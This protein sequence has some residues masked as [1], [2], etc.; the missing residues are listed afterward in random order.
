MK[1]SGLKFKMSIG[2]PALSCSTLI[3]GIASIVSLIFPT[4]PTNYPNRYRVKLRRGIECRC[5]AVTTHQEKRA[6]RCDRTMRHL[7]RYCA[8]VS[9]FQSISIVVIRHAKKIDAVRYIAGYLINFK[10]PSRHAHYRCREDRRQ[11]MPSQTRLRAVAA[12]KILLRY[13]LH[14]IALSFSLAR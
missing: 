9:A 3:I 5:S 10:R 14:C 7:A 6:L 12:T 8:V 2:R 4:T 13:L 1:R 11:Y